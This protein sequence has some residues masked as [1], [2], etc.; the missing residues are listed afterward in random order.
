M[1]E[2]VMVKGAVNDDA[3]SAPN[4]QRME[5]HK[6]AQAVLDGW[7]LADGQQAVMVNGGGALTR[8]V[9]PAIGSVLQAG[10]RLATPEEIKRYEAG[11]F[12][13]D[14]GQVAAVREIPPDS[15]EDLPADVP[16]ETPP[17]AQAS[18]TDE[19]SEEIPPPPTPKR[20]RR[21]KA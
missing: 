17:G 8:A 15:V 6:V 13:A 14:P 18:I 16:D 12:W 10:G 11:A 21:G 19:D 3:A 9:G 5:P 1:S 2:L 4:V 7:R 20:G